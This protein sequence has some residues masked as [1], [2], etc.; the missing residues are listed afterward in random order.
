MTIIVTGGAGFIGSNFIFYMLDKHPDDQIICLVAGTIERLCSA[1]SHDKIL[2]V[3]KTLLN[4]SDL[5]VASGS[6]GIWDPD[7]SLDEIEPAPDIFRPQLEG[8]EKNK[9][10]A[11]CKR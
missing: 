11:V 8:I 3:P 6:V 10:S 9:I 4:L 1:S 2:F 7:A 5:K